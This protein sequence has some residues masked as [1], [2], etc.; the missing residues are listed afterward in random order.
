M[1]FPDFTERSKV[2]SASQAVTLQSTCSAAA[3]PT[4]LV[5]NP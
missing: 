5:M 3:D 1:N 2:F 4:A